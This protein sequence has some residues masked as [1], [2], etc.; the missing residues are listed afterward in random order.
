[1][2]SVFGELVKCPRCEFAV[3]I[4][5]CVENKQGL[6]H[7]FHI[8]CKSIS[9]RWLRKFFSSK[10][11]TREGCGSKPFDINLRAILAFREIGR[12]EAG[13]ETFCGY[14]NIPPPMTESTYNNTVKETMLPIYLQVAQNDM[15][16]AAADLRVISNDD[17]VD[18]NEEDEVCDIAASFDGTWQRHGY[19][20]LNGVVTTI[21]I[22]TGK[23]L[24]YECLTKTCK[25]CEMLQS[26]KGTEYEKFE[27]DHACP[28]NHKGSAEAMEVSGVLRL[29]NKSVKNLKLCYMNYIGDGDSKAYPSV[30]A[31]QPYG[32]NKIPAKWECVGHVQKRVGGRL[33]RLKK[34]LVVRFC[35]MERN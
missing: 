35:L 21:S 30:V 8:K 27:M 5:H 1:M 16:E 10:E 29:Y 11:A 33:R 25:S 2:C 4:N 14:M 22:D 32:P 18:I 6:A 28:I 19:S 3:E 7:E 34:I 15:E 24:A 31:A 26:R 23:C 20:S 17:S 9:C 12:G 13:I